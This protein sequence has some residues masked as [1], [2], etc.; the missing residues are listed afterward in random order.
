[1]VERDARLFLERKSV[2]SVSTCFV[3]PNAHCPVCGIAVYFYANLIG[4]RVYCDGLGWPWPKHPCTD[5]ASGNG[6]YYVAPLIVCRERSQVTEIMVAARTAGF[7]P[8]AGF[9]KRYGHSPFEL[10]IVVELRRI[11]FKNVINAQLLS[12]DVP[13]FFTFTSAK[14]SPAIGDYVSFNGQEVSF[15]NPETL[16][17][18]SYKAMKV[19]PNDFASAASGGSK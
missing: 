2:R 4:S 11:G 1:M 17:P 16:T 18:Q 8:N 12:L 13:V 15:I 7:D 9:T 3:V 5:N 10:L 6:T 19:T 14:F